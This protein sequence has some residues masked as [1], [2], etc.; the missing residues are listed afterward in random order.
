YGLDT[1]RR[2]GLRVDTTID[3]HLQKLARKA[4]DGHLGAPDR[5]GAIVTVDP[6]TGYVRA[7]ASSSRYGNS[8][9]NLAAQGHRQAGST[10]KV[11]V[12]M[13]ALRRG[14]DPNRHNY[15]SRPPQ[16]RRP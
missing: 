3:L 8:K 12:L 6:K 11:M 15:G 9:Y 13:D 10:F 1:V 7:M 16:R 2:G 4:L 5:A 14:V